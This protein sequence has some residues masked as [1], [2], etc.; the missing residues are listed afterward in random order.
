M[1]RYDLTPDRIGPA[2]LALCDWTPTLA[3]AGGLHPGDL[4]WHLRSRD[5]GAFLWCE[6]SSASA[7]GILDG[8]VLRVTTS[9]DADVAIIAMDAQRNLGD[10]FERS[11]GLPIAG[12]QP[13]GEEPWVVMS[14]TPRVGTVDD[15]QVDE[16]SAADRV[17]LQRAAFANSTFTL[18]R[19]HRMK[20]SAA[21]A[22][23]VERMVRTA[24]GRPAAAATGWFAGKER[25]GLL[26]PVGTH[27]ALRGAGHGRRAVLGACY[28]LAS[29]GA[30]AVAVVTPVANTAAAAL[31]RSAGFEILCTRLD[32]S[33]HC[34]SL[35]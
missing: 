3:P 18:D 27:P 32:W 34:Q 7:V 23:A 20:H 33:P 29:R 22:L 21:G 15:E 4:G 25:C 35:G 5:A 12:W 10:L 2:L 1:R 16:T 26:E 6:G 8:N 19:W 28:A 11:D 30:S 31:Y 9:P 24:D 13:D 14:W 17:A